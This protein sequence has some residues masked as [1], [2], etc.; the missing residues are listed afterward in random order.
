MYAFLSVNLDIKRN[1]IYFF[2]FLLQFGFLLIKQD[3]LFVAK[4]KIIC[5]KMLKY[6]N[7][8]INKNKYY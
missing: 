5:Y 8:K 6:N 4:T 2:V 1:K 3:Q 7:W